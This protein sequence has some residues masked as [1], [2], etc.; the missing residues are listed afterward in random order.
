MLLL[1]EPAEEHR[2]EHVQRNHTPSPRYLPAAFS[3]MTGRVFQFNDRGAA[4]PQDERT[5][6]DAS[7]QSGEL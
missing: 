5:L 1:L 2:D 3:D 7:S 6:W 4:S